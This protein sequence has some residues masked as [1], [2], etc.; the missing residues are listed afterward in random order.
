MELF[1]KRGDG[2]RV[3]CPHCGEV[4]Y[5]WSRYCWNCGKNVYEK[6]Y[7]GKTQLGKLDEMISRLAKNDKLRTQLKLLLQIHINRIDDGRW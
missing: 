5:G 2:M 4:G 7:E 6:S 3:I 1:H